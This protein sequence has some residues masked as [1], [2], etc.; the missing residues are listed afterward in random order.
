MA[1]LNPPQYL[2]AGSYS[3]RLDRLALSALWGGNPAD[4]LSAR[5]AI[6][7]GKGGQL[8]VTQT[9]TA[10]MSVVVASGIAM[11]A[12]GN[13]VLQGSYVC[14]N[15]DN[16][17][18]TVPASHAT[19]PRRDIVV[20]RVEDAQ[21]AGTNNQWVLE[22]IAGTAA[23]TPVT[24]ATPI[25]SF[26]L[27]EIAVAAG[28][29]SITNANITDTRDYLVTLGGIRPSTVGNGN[30]PGE[31][32]WNATLNV[33]EV[34]SGSAWVARTLPSLHAFAVDNNFGT[35]TSTTFATLLTG[36]AATAL[37]ASFV[38]PPS[39]RVLIA[40]GA[41]L[42]LNTTTAE[43]IVQTGL[44]INGPGLANVDPVDHELLEFRSNGKGGTGGRSS[45][46]YVDGRVTPGGSYS[47]TAVHRVVASAAAEAGIDSRRIDV[48]PVP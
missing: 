34:W 29:T 3:G 14:I 41:Y 44:R 40:L 6:V 36:G 24:P 11:I 26:K 16:V 42:Q 5:T 1:T 46:A 4:T 33:L 43:Q 18:L 39:G 37:A 13:I 25:S 31:A 48:T 7:A 20:A 17:T 15:D 21:Y 10:S 32:R 47:L 45:I 2:E 38:A 35:T 9:A 23:T 19:L 8:R 12:G 28:A 22:V 27:A 30:F